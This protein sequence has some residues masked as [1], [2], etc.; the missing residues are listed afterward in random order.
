MNAA[1]R[2]GRADDEEQLSVLALV[3]GTGLTQWGRTTAVDVSEPS[4]DLLGCTTQLAYPG[5]AVTPDVQR[6]EP[7]LTLRPD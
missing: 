3:L 2:G 5:N 6:E 7:R 4:R 1:C